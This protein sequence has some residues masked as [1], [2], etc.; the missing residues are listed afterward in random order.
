M[1]PSSTQRAIAVEAD[2]VNARITGCT[3]V[4]GVND[5]ARP[6]MEIDSAVSCTVEN[7]TITVFPNGAASSIV[8]I[9][10]GSGSY[11]IQENVISV[12]SISNGACRFVNV[13][14]NESAT[15]VVRGNTQLA[16]GFPLISCVTI[17]P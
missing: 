5:D 15:I 9:Q 4:R 17:N 6:V 2:V 14:Y 10:S 11:F 13:N 16:T 7:C 3:I 1:N 12:Y 8:L